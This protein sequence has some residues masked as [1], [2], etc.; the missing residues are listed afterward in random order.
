MI[1]YIDNIVHMDAR[2]KRCTRTGA[3]LEEDGAGHLEGPEHA[4]EV[5][6]RRRGGQH[7]AVVIIVGV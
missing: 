7:E 4:V 2:G 6:G 3:A 5:L 1:G